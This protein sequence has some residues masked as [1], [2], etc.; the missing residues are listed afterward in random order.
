MPSIDN[1][2]NYNKTKSRN[3]V[4]FVNA[5]INFCIYQIYNFNLNPT[6][7]KLIFAN[8]K[9]VTY[10]LTICSPYHAHVEISWPIAGLCRNSELKFMLLIIM[11][12]SAIVTLVNSP[13]TMACLHRSLSKS[14]TKLSQ[15]QKVVFVD[16]THD[17][18]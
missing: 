11:T 16:F 15:R 1:D 8:P 10:C 9:I 3:D 12:T 7:I 4:T 17:K 6:N 2:W 13:I 14:V 5:F 18:F